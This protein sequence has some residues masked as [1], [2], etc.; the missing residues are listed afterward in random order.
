[1]CMSLIPM[2]G[3]R[4]QH[5]HE[6]QYRKRHIFQMTMLNLQL[7]FPRRS[8]RLPKLRGLRAHKKSPCGGA[9]LSIPPNVSEGGGSG[10]NFK[11]SKMWRF[12]PAI[13]V[14]KCFLFKHV[15]VTHTYGWAQGPT[16]PRASIQ[17][18]TH[19]S[20]DNAES[21]TLVSKAKHK[22]PEAPRPKSAQKGPLQRR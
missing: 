21:S 20:N 2:D 7:W 18:A 19:F 10:R 3:P 11:P 15:H 14:C 13:V 22:A 17:K 4:A 16:S 1:M 5:R 12:P 6:P 8:T 9:E